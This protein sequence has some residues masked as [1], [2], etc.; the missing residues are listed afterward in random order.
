MAFVPEREKRGYQSRGM[1]LRK[2]ARTGDISTLCSMIS[3]KANLE[4]SDEDCAFFSFGWFHGLSKH[5]PDEEMCANYNNTAL[6][7]ASEASNAEIVEEL[8]KAKARVN[9]R[10]KY[11]QSALFHAVGRGNAWISDTNNVTKFG[12]T[13]LMKA[14]Y[15]IHHH[16]KYNI[17][18]LLEKKADPNLQD[19]DG[20]T[21]ASICAET[22]K[23]RCLQSMIL[24]KAKVDTPDKSP[25]TLTSILMQILNCTHPRRA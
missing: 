19:M 21:A 6:V 3:S 23:L 2:A 22:N 1:R 24:K 8:L 15:T 18:N 13:A 14:A 5:T 25:A 4:S 17:D 10:D 11:G 12:Q 7:L 20:R 16:T 9:A